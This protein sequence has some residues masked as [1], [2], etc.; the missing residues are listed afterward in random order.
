MR[1]QLSV[2]LNVV[3][4]LVIA[5]SFHNAQLTPPPPQMK[6]LPTTASGEDTALPSAPPMDDDASTIVSTRN[7]N[8][9]RISPLHHET[10]SPTLVPQQNMFTTTPSMPR[11]SNPPPQTI[12]IETLAPQTVAPSAA[13]PLPSSENSDSDNITVASAIATL[14]AGEE[15]KQFNVLGS[16]AMIRREKRW[17]SSLPKENVPEWRKVY[18][19]NQNCASYGG[20]PRTPTD[21]QPKIFFFN[22]YN[23]ESD[24][25]EV[26]LDEA[27]PVIDY[28][29]ILESN[30][31]FQGR[32]KPIYFSVEDPKFARYKDKIIHHLYTP[33]VG[34]EGKDDAAHF[35]IELK[36]R[37][38]AYESV[39]HIIRPG[40]YILQSDVDEIVRREAL[41]I[42]KI[43][44]F[45]AEKRFPMTFNIRYTWYRYDLLMRAVWNAPRVRVFNVSDKAFERN[46][47][48]SKYGFQTSFPNAGWHCSYCLTIEHL[49]RKMET[50]SHADQNNKKDKD[51]RNLF[52]SIC[53]GQMHGSTRRDRLKKSKQL[54]RIML[55]ADNKNLQDADVP[56]HVIRNAQQYNYLLPGGLC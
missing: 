26:K 46:M 27:Y 2:G 38:E 43:C 42:L 21:P 29:V 19:Y 17:E 10:N 37:R 51:P 5:Y 22:T 40:D 49:I 31:T 53:K 3:L 30:I 35:R 50:F 41:E 28:L 6:N 13:P 1:F 54:K 9:A 12:I 20:R 14:S 45:D 52:K 44:H 36:A 7:D 16:Q 48:P 25:L 55:T 8:N 24:H 23:G 18:H 34:D 39:K 56:M 33:P 47:G 4:L 15:G 11:V 32:P